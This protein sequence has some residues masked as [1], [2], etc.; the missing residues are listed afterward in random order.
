L[1]S[2]YSPFFKAAFGDNSFVEGQTQTTNLEDVEPK[3]FGMVVQ[4][5]YT[6]KFFVGGRTGKWP[7]YVKAWFLAERFLMFKLQ[8]SIINQIQY[9]LKNGNIRSRYK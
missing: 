2:Y 5:A 4:W 7:D 9:F 1:I 8:N 6:Q 3:I